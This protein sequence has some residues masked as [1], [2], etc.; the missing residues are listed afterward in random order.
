M[1]RVTGSPAFA[2]D[3]NNEDS[4]RELRR[5]TSIQ[6]KHQTGAPDLISL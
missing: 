3:D 6:Q 2:G 4:Y 1:T 5:F